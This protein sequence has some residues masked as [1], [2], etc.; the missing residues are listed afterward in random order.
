MKRIA[1]AVFS[2]LCCFLTETASSQNAIPFRSPTS[3]SISI[4]FI[5]KAD[6]YKYEKKD[7]AT[8]LIFLVGNVELQQEKTLIYCDSMVLNQKENYIESFGKVHIN[9]NDSVNIYSDYMKYFVDKKMVLFQKNV[10]LTDGK[11]I[12]T[13]DELHY[14]MAARIGTYNSGGKVVNN[15]SVLTSR[16]GV[17]YAETRDVYFKKN[18]ILRDPQYDLATDSL[19]YN[20]QTQISTFITWTDIVFRDS[21]HRTVHTKEGF[22]D[23]RNKRAQFGQRP[24]IV[25]GTKTVIANNMVTNDSSKV[26]IATGNVVF[27]DTAEGVVIHSNRMISDG[28]RQTL[29]ATENPLAILKQDQDSIYITGDTLFSGM[30]SDWERAQSARPDTVTDKRITDSLSSKKRADS[31][32]AVANADTLLEGGHPIVDTSTEKK[33]LADSLLANRYG[34]ESILAAKHG[35]DSVLTTMHVSDSLMIKKQAAKASAKKEDDSP[36]ARRRKEAVL[37]RQASDSVAAAHRAEL[38]LAKRMVDSIAAKRVTDS[39]TAIRRVDSI[40]SKRRQDSLLAIQSAIEAVRVADSLLELHRADSAFAKRTFDSIL[41]RIPAN[42]SLA[43]RKSD[44][45]H[46]QRFADSL[47]TKKNKDALAELAAANEPHDPNEIDPADSNKRFLQ[48]YHHVRIFS[49]SLQAV[50]DSLWYS[51]K[52]SIFRLFTD[53]I[54]WGNGGY[55]VTG[56]TI[57]LFTKN[58]KA[59]RLYVFENAL[60]VNKAEENLYN[61]LKGITL[62]GYFKNGTI[63]YMRAKGNAESIYYTRDD[64]QAFVGVNKSQADIIDMI[65]RNKALNRV[66][67]R[68]DVTGTMSP[69]RKVNFDDMRLRNFRWLEEIRP[70][71]KYELF[72]RPVLKTKSASDFDTLESESDK[73][74]GSI[75]A[76]VPN[77]TAPDPGKTMPDPGKTTPAAATDPGKLPADPNK[78]VSIPIPAPAINNPAPAD[79]VKP[80]SK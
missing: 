6:N 23:L 44:S 76:S 67:L 8:E 45:L 17:Y 2:T 79:S 36:R 31:L 11:G 21:T 40:S 70:K 77:K 64:K 48:V 61:Q 60:A 50:C 53:P 46:A 59:D 80:V 25:D 55:Q 12:L 10:K 1:F 7:S 68:N 78:P 32:L 47:V 62:N 18:V 66:V 15:G 41:S 27:K 5:R 4:V 63:D 51:G 37:A 20:T 29:L 9:D 49:D 30:L 71:T 42:A 69:I 73:K 24:T 38:R 28:K 34:V 14:D 58:K 74:P 39:L 43:R 56:D 75:P 72:E 35:M 33:H 54:V 65:W 57:F 52:D 3:D 22:Y 19:L 16:E 13:T 26:S